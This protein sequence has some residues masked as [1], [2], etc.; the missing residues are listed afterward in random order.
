MLILHIIMASDM[1]HI[2]YCLGKI[3]FAAL[4]VC[5][6]FPNIMQTL[7]NMEEDLARLYT[8]YNNADLSVYILDPRTASYSQWQGS[9]D[10]THEKWVL[11]KDI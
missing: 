9:V 11:S 2:S 8:A 7:F 5:P 1:F 3:L 10:V 4:E 6:C